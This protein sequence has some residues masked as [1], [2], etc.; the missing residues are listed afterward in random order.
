MGA[1]PLANER[2]ALRSNLLLLRSKAFAIAILFTYVSAMLKT[3]RGSCLI[4]IY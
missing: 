2:E 3:A 4:N 1:S